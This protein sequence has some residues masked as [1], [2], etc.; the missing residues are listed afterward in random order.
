MVRYNG[1]TCAVESATL[2]GWVDAGLVIAVCPEVAG[3][4]AIP[5]PPAEVQGGGG[6]SVLD[7][8]ACVRTVAGEDVTRAFVRGAHCA[9]EAGREN[10][11]RLAILK[12]SSPSCG[13]HRI[14]D[15]RFAGVLIPG[16]G[17]TAALL[18]R[19]GIA[20]FSEEE[21]ESAARFLTEI[22]KGE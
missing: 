3:G 12:E 21:L 17:V 20:V 16:E 14:H 15:G 19:N 6:P 22:D 5:R 1:G 7:G 9:L 2:K 18:L 10:G 11:A 13:R 4:L 8:S